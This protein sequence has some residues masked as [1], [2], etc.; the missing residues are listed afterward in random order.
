MSKKKILY[1][2]LA[3][4]AVGVGSLAVYS[5]HKPTKKKRSTE[6]KVWKYGNDINTDQLFPGKYT[7]TCS[8]LEEIKPH[9]LEDL[10]QD[11]AQN[12][13]EGD[14]LFAG[15]NF[16]CGSSRE[17]PALGLKGVGIQAI[18][19]KSFARIFYRAS[20]N[21]GL[22]LIE[23]PKAIDAFQ[24]GDNVEIDLERSVIKVGEKEF[25]FP[26]LP[27]EILAIREAGG[28]LP[29]SRKLLAERKKNQ[30][31]SEK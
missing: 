22:I 20:I 21:Q 26:K 15:K 28:L 3:L 29:Y 4:A 12:V 1:G 24:E 31:K 13:S 30:Q 23:C 5:F 2:G 17:Q 27:K 11:F 16:G 9:L 25:E 14:F 7:Y 6:T 8:T 10:D 18:V 19:A